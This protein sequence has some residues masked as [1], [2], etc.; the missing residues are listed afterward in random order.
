VTRTLPFLDA[1]SFNREEESLA[2]PTVAASAG[3]GASPFVS[4][5]ELEE[6]GESFDPR[7]NE[8]VAFLTEMYDEEMD[9]AL[10]EIVN[11]AAALSEQEF[12]DTNPAAQARLLTQHFEP[13]GREVRR[14]LDAL[15]E[16]FSNVDAA[17]LQES[18][19]DRFLDQ[20]TPTSQL[21]PSF[22]NLFGR[23]WNG[24]KKVANKAVGL[25]KQG[26]G[27]VGN[28]ALGPIFTKLKALVDPLIR[29]VAQFAI[30][31]LPSALQPVARTLA[32]KLGISLEVNEENLEG[33]DEATPGVETIQR[34]FN[35]Q[36]ADLLFATSEVKQD[37]EVSRAIAA[38][39]VAM[40]NPLAELDRAR[41]QFIREIGRLKEGEDPTPLLEEFL[42]AV[43][44]VLRVG[45]KLIG[46]KRV[47]DFL[48]KLVSK[49]IV[50]LIGPQNATALSQA[51]VDA[52]LK[53]IN[54]EVTQQDEMQAAGSAVAATVEDTVRRVAA[55][56]E[57]I[58]DNQELLE[59]FALEAFEQAAAANLPPV[60]SEETYSRRPELRESKNLPGA[61]VHMPLRGRKKYKKFCRIARTRITPQKARAVESFDGTTLAEF[62][63]EQLGLP[64]GTDL[65]AEVH[66]FESIPGTLLPEVARLEQNTPGLGSNN[67]AS[68][69]QF[70]P[71]T[72]EAASVLLGEPG[73]GRR[74][75]PAAMSRQSADAGQRFYYLKTGAGKPAPGGDLTHP[76]KLRRS[77]RLKLILDFPAG[78]IRACVFLSEV[79]AQGIAVKLRQQG[80]V[81][82]IVAS[83][84]PMIERRLTSA[85]TAGAHGRIKIIHETVEP[86]QALG[87]ALRR[88][89]S[90][91]L[92]VLRFKLREWILNALT[93][94]LK[95]QAA[96]FIAASE[97]PADGVTLLV[98]IDHPPGMDMLRQALKGRIP[99]LGDFRFSGAAPTVTI[100]VT[101]GYSHG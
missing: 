85:L 27:F 11:E 36:V 53:L 90:A 68:Y 47:V 82:A 31:K 32:G 2:Q 69:G 5:Y 93:E 80:R 12:A 41:D 86:E 71:L 15:A 17:T 94:F 70:H 34:E 28:L 14:S 9:A 46:R 39:H 45:I 101:S 81:G 51:I 50:R 10:F 56:P 92:G 95:Q 25:A 88:I 84:R 13:L 72:E 16:Q 26:I 37:L 83:L 91:V 62:L 76:G 42:P 20:Y 44:P 43:L 23:I 35:K 19:I 98:T 77:S 99:S 1:S 8:Y 33:E 97:S 78:Q 22:E 89:P 67:E 87:G 49:L 58:L 30:G 57:Y 60:L 63:E 54:L 4:I 61:W 40:D 96:Q 52:G 7:S 65:E 100:S 59:A 38:S 24:I 79:K 29:R 3:F 64:S 73:L 75:N 66:L 18:E 74:A 48:A 55:L 21:S 6:Q